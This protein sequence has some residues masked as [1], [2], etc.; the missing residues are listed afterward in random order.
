MQV[1]PVENTKQIKQFH[2]VPF[3]LYAD[4]PACIPHVK[5]E[6]EAV[7]H[8]KSNTYFKHGVACRWILVDENKK[9][10]GR[11]AAFINE[12]RAYTEKQATGGCGFFECINNQD[13]ANLLFNTAKN[14]LSE[15]GMEAMD[16]PINFG[17]R[18]KYWGL[19]VKGYN[20]PPNYGNNYHLPYYKELFENYGFLPYFQQY[21]FVR[22][23]E[24]ELDKR[25]QEKATRIRRNSDYRFSNMTEKPLLEYAGDFIAVYNEA[26]K[27][28]SNFKPMKL[29]H[30]EK[31]LKSMKPIIDKRVAWFCYYKGEPVGFIINLPE[32][33][34][35]FKHNKG[36]MNLLGKLHFLFRKTFMPPKNLWAVVFGIHPKHQGKGLEGALFTQIR[37]DLE[38][39]LPYENIFVSWIGSFNPK[40]LHIIRSVGAEDY[41][42]LCTYR[43]LFNPNAEFFPCPIIQ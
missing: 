41:Q 23:A 39:G 25:Y 33:N 6:V 19:L 28:H 21:C 4:S 20:R 29:S 7:F 37:D 34:E 14:W 11:I 8:A 36:N 35:I 17:E 24:K 30:A 26:W 5:Q 22:S 10:I 31:L 2:Q 42:E 13:A 16:G 18:N 15:R 1:I 27:T 40:M 12:K 32:I 3:K 38:K 9:C 43:Y